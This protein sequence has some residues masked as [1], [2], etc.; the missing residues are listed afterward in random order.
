M[1]RHLSAFL[2]LDKPVGL[3][4]NRVLQRVKRLFNVKKAGHVGTLDPLAS[5]M[6]PICFGAATRFA[7]YLVSEYK[8]YLVSARFGVKT[9]TGDKEG[10]VVSERIVPVITEEN[11]NDLMDSFRGEITQ[12]P[13]MYSALKH[14]GKPLYEYARKGVEISRPARPAVIHS[15]S[16]LEIVDETTCKFEVRCSKGTYVRTLIEDLGEAVGCGAHVIELRRTRVGDFDEAQMISLDCLSEL[17]DQGGFAELD[18][19]LM[20]VSDLCVG[21]DSLHLDH[22]K[23]LDWVHGRDVFVRN[24]SVNTSLITLFH[25]SGEFLGI[26]E[27]QDDGRLKVKKCLPTTGFTFIR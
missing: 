12:I 1:K 14:K 3:S 23:S 8:T 26:A 10:D 13:P 25:E 19:R 16:L 6:L 17:F 9:S 5:G 24:L 27:P 2:L 4:S 21:F 11:L 20:S 15:F 18:Q 7:D 22:I